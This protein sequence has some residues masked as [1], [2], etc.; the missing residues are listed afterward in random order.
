MPLTNKPDLGTEI[1]FDGGAP[2]EFSK[3]PFNLTMD[4]DKEK[5]EGLKG[6]ACAGPKAAPKAGVKKG[7]APK[8]KAE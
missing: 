4:V 2:Q 7:V 6:E 3:D 1:Q 5:I 8:K